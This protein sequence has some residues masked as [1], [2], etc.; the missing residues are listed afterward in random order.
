[1]NRFVRKRGAT[2]REKQVRTATLA[3]RLGSQSPNLKHCLLPSQ[4]TAIQEGQEPHALSQGH[5]PQDRPLEQR[6]RFISSHQTTLNQICNHWGF[7]SQSLL[8]KTFLNKCS[9]ISVFNG[10]VARFSIM[11]SYSVRRLTGKRAWDASCGERVHD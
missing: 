2:P 7:S 5:R 4:T 11:N 3:Q 8:T 6:P 1:M 10:K 9:R